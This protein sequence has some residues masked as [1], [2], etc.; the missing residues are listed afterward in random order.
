MAGIP[1]KAGSII[2]RATDLLSPEGNTEKLKFKRFPGYVIR[3]ALKN[4]E[5][6]EED[7]IDIV[8]LRVNPQQLNITKRKVIQKV[9]TNA[10]GRFVVFD[11]GSELTMIN[12]SG[13]TGN[14]LPESITSGTNPVSSFLQDTVGVLSPQTPITVPP[15]FGTASSIMQNLILSNSTYTE[16]LEMSPKYRTFKKLEKMYDL[17]DAD[18]DILLLEMGEEVYRGFFEDFSF[19]IIAEAPWNWKYNI[20]FTSLYS[21]TDKMRRW[22]L[23]YE[24]QNT[25]FVR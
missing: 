4:D 14:L 1:S 12:I 2:Q 25:N 15:A 16:V 24:K 3:N 9:Q 23:Q 19:D 22:D 8:T 21:L 18:Q 10:P 17:L 13:N 7:Q 6:I 20:A 11:W 5:S